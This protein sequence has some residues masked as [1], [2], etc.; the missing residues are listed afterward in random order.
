MKRYLFILLLL[1]CGGCGTGYSIES[2]EPFPN[3]IYGGTRSDL[4]SAHLSFVADVPFS[5]VADTV[6]LPYTI[7]R[8]I[9]NANHP[10]EKPQY[11]ELGSRIEA[12]PTTAPAPQAH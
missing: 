1:S 8:S 6:V 9:Y 5:L 12:K 11:D 7:P 2:N 3:I 10:E 4:A